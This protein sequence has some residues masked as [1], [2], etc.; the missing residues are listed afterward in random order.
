MSST[1]NN[2]QRYDADWQ[3]LV[4][5][6]ENILGRAAAAGATQAEVGANIH[7]GLATTV[8]LGET[9]TIEYSRDRGVGITVYYGQSKGSASTADLAPESIDLALSKACS[10]ARFT[11]E[12]PYA[13]LA[14][15]DRMATEFPDLDIWHPWDV[16]AAEAVDMALEMEAAALE[17]DAAITNSEGAT[18][19]ADLSLSVYGNSHG[20]LGKGRATRQGA[21]CVVIGSQDGEMQRDYW[22]DIAR[23]ADDLMPVRDVGRKAAERTCSRMGARKLDTVKAPVLFVPDQARGLISH[24]VGAISGSALYRGASFLRDHLGKKIFPEFM[25]IYEVPSERR[26]MGAA[27]YDAEGVAT[28]DRDVIKDG[29]LEGYVLGS[30]SARKLGL[31]TTANSGGVH[32]LTVEPGELQ[33]DQLVKD[34]GTGLIVTEMMGQ[35]VKLVSGDYSRGASGFWVEQG[36]IAY[37]VHE[38]TVAGNLRD[39]FQGIVAVG[40]DMDYRS[41]IRCGSLLM[42]E[43]TIAGS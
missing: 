11:E 21:T 8:R 29:V 15:A 22:Y 4:D 20:F 31:Q 36:E 9:E 33:F 2:L 32:N 19:S 27:A 38:I 12:D 3:N 18:I 23:R 26:S 7:R 37:P 30:Y 6:V 35:G 34:M 41:G 17:H 13:G 39:M 10:I 42:S 24:F 16:A 1:N 25:H 5:V 40:A 28:K 14:P 43:M